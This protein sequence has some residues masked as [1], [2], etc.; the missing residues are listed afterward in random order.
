MVGGPS[1]SH[2]ER[3]EVCS[4]RS[5]PKCLY[6]G[7]SAVVTREGL[8]LH[9]SLCACADCPA[10][11]GRPSVGTKID[12]GRDYVFL[13]ECTMDCSGFGPG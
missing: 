11:V 4:F 8:S 1:A 12:L 9:K 5:G 7:P 3:S 10:G 13:V 2:S 6:C